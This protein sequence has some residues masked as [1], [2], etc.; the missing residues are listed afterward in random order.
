[1]FRLINADLLGTGL[2][3]LGVL[4]A[5]DDQATVTVDS[6]PLVDLGMVV[7]LMDASNNNTKLITAEAVL[8]VD[9][10]NNTITQTSAAAGTAAGDYYT[11]AGT[12]SSAGSLHMAGILAWIS[13]ANP[14]SVVGNLG[15]INRS[16]TGN[17]F[18]KASV[19]SNGGTN[20]PL[21][22]DLQLAATNSV[23]KRG[24]KP[25]NKW[26]SNLEILS[27]YHENLRED[28]FFALGQVKEFGSGVGVGR[29]QAAMK[30]G[31]NEDGRTV[32]RFSGVEW[33]ADPFFRSNRLVGFNDEHF[34][35]GHGENE[36]PQV[37]SE[38]FPG[39][40]IPYFTKTASAYFDIEYYWQA[41]LLCDAPTS[42]VII[43]DL[44]QS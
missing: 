4:P 36:T 26:L 34:W 3:E 30:Q 13:D 42:A 11:V 8:A 29:D 41:E 28:T 22:E 33:H 7:D 10:E 2:G 14:E 38:C 27:R 37:L 12:V 9:V 31:E 35:I 40:D 23:R 24:G 25:V 19:K 5:V 21:T 1:M 20:R 32:Y 15:G 43:K 44:A 39:G 18:W 16:T 6:M 17:D